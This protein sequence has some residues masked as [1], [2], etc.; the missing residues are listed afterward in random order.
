MVFQDGV[1]RKV[2]LCVLS[3]VILYRVKMV[4]QDGVSRS[5]VIFFFI[6]GELSFRMKWGAELQA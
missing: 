4:F 3:N 5:Q 6:S 1:S 2:L